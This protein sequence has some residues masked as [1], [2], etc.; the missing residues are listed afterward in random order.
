MT[1]DAE[2]S[3]LSEVGLGLGQRQRP[4]FNDMLDGCKL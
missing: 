3:Y 1:S 4:N 2:E